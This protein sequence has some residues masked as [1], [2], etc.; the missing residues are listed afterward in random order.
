MDMALTI[1]DQ[2]GDAA[3]SDA[4]PNT[5]FSP[6]VTIDT[7]TTGITKDNPTIDAG[8]VQT[9]G[10]LGDYVWFDTD[11]DGIQD[12]IEQ[13]VPDITVILSKETSPGVFTQVATK[14][15][16]ANGKYLFDLLAS[17]NYKVTFQVPTDK[18]LTLQDQGSDDAKDSDADP[19]TGMSQ[20]VAINANGVGIAKDNPTIDAGLICIDPTFIATPTPAE[21]GDGVAKSNAKITLTGV[22]NGTRY[23]FNVGSTYTNNK[24]FAT[25]TVIPQ[26][27]VIANALPNPTTPTQNYTIRVFNQDGCFTDKTVTIEQTL[28]D[29]PPAKCV[30]YTVIKSTK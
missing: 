4:D 24:S 2:D 28:C 29:C 13:G 7:K 16:D 10:S 5:G 9:Y 22:Q 12:L 30:P 27:G 26:G 6:K 1:L 3:D 17:G 19:T 8:F 25:A 23:D 21:C 15:T 20:V 18:L 14:T 11:K